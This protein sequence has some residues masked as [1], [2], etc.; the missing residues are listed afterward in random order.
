MDQRREKLALYQF[1]CN[2]CTN[3]ALYCTCV[4]MSCRTRREGMLTHTLMV[5]KMFRNAKCSGKRTR[6]VVNGKE[7]PQLSPIS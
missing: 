5:S 1:F 3:N 4:H 7:R 6:T 2:S